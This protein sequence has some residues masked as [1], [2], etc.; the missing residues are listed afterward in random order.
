M[1][2]SL[3]DMMRKEGLNRIQIRHDW[4]SGTFRLY[5]AREWD[6]DTR[7]ADYNRS[8][9]AWSLHPADGRWLSHAETAA[10]FERHGSAEHL[11]RIQELMRKGRHM[12]LDGYWH[13]RLDIRFVN[14]IHS[15]RRGV[16]NRRSSLVMGGIRRHEPD[17]P[18]LDVFVD[19]LNLGRGMTFK[20]VAARLPMGGCKTT[21][22]MPPVDLDDLE[23]VGFLAF[24]TDRTRN[25]AGPDMNFPPEL[26][27][28]VKQHFSL[29]FVGGPA[30]PLGPTGTPTAHG[31]HAAVRQAARF[32]WGSES[33]GERTIAVLG[34]GAVGRP[35][36]GLY[37]ADGARL[38][39]CDRSPAAVRALLEAHPGAPIEV[40]APEEI[41]G[42]EADILS[43]AAA[44]GL[45]TAENIPGLRFA[46]VMGGANNVL[47]ASSQEEEIVLARQLAEHGVLYQVDWWHNIAGVMAGYE[48]YVE[49]EHA[50][51]GRLLAKVEALCSE[52]TWH[53]L[54]A[55]A[56]AGITPTEQAYRTVEREA[57][58]D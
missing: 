21:V 48:E 54:S 25:T 39:V 34:L 36:A 12:L 20:N 14:H 29:H 46:I 8:F 7:F 17:E 58:G 49:Q 52:S 42:V 19:G 16:N 51:M 3:F 23:Q 13:E 56:E 30:G 33:L 18:E 35:L 4:R 45:L 9:T 40:V 24:A 22:Q 32:L 47:R 43:P 27:D 37:L 2:H 53:N 28:V 1:T 55:A 41:L 50:D 38:V 10:A 26:A 57:Y 11:A 31:V 6:A 5:A 15:D 44:G